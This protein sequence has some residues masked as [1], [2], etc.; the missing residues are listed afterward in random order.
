MSD[1]DLISLGMGTGR[2]CLGDYSALSF[3]TELFACISL[4]FRELDTRM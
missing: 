2:G 3:E 1:Q 4:T